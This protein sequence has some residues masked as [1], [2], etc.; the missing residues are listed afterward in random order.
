MRIERV[1]Q[2]RVIQLFVEQL[3]YS[4]AGNLEDQLN[5]NIREEDLKAWLTAQNKYSESSISRALFDF[6][7]STNISPNDDLYPINKDVYSKLRYG[8]KVK[9]DATDLVQTVWLID[10][11]NPLNNNFTI[12]EEVTV[13]GAN[14]KRPDIVLYI[15]GI[16]LGVL[17]LK[18]AS[19]VVNEGIRQNLDN[20]QHRFIKPFFTTI[21]LVLAG[22]DSQGLYYGTTKTSEKYFLKWKE[23]N[24]NYDPNKNILDQH[25]LQFC[26]KTRLLE[27]IHDFVVF[28]A[29]LKKLCRPNQFFGVKKAQ[30]FVSR[31][32]GG[33]IWHTQGSGKSLTMVWLAK[34]IREHQTDARL[35]IVTDRTELDEQIEKVFKGVDEPIYKTKSGRDLLDKLNDTTPWL[36]CSLIHKFGG[37]DENDIDEFIT[38]LKKPA[39]FKPKGNLYVFIDECHRTNSGNLHKAMKELLP[40]ALFIGF[41]GT[42]LLKADKKKSIEIFGKYIHT[43]KFDEAVQDGVV[44]DLLYEARDVDQKVT[45]QKGID[46][47]FE[48][49]TVGMNDL[50]KAELKQ[51]WGTIQ[52]ILST[53]DRLQKIAFDIIKDFK[54]KPRLKDGKGNAILVSGSIYEACRYYEIFQ[55]FGFKKCA[56]ITS[57]EPN[58]ASI[59]GETTGDGETEKIEQ[60]DIYQKMLNGKDRETFE[61]ETKKQFIDE[62]ANMQ[63]LIVVDKLLTGFDAPA[64]T[65]LYI[66]KQMQDHGLFQAICRVNRTEKEDKEFGYIVDYKN[67]FN[68]L[69]QSIADYTSDAFDNFEEDDVRGLLVDRLV[70]TRECMDDALE[71]I[72]QLCIGVEP[73]RQIEQFIKFFCGNTEDKD[74]LKE[75]EEKRLTFYK[76]VVALIRAY[77]NVAAEMKEA[78]YT[79]A[80]AEKIKATVDSYT[81]HRNS[82]KAASGDYIDL[83]K[84]E[85][86]M[87][88]LLDMYLSADPSRTI[89][90]FGDATLLQIIVEQGI[91]E[92]TGK[93]PNA[94][95]NSKEAMAETLEANMRKVITQEMPI[96]PVYYEKM[97]VLLLELIKQR[98]NGAIKYAE[99]LK[100]VEE[101]TKNIQP[102]ARKSEYPNNIN[103]P[104]KQALYDNL[105]QDED[106]AIVMDSEIQYVKK[107]N[108][109]GN[110]IK[111]REVR[112]AIAKHIDD[113]AKVDEIFEIIKNQKEYR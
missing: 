110:T 100:K 18:R 85:P 99:F 53:K 11:Q 24:Y 43:Y 86:E 6:K 97:S 55:N 105:E 60:Y 106:L 65:Y 101:L 16:A 8:V 111:E 26:D 21:Q 46:D 9:D 93:L 64:C 56:I 7:K 35:L 20:Q 63:L 3:G 27:L 67:L 12:A 113:S 66:D 91:E 92:A 104:A 33:I 57:Y 41:T 34:W 98:K 107:D 72:H 59:K 73:P 50:P 13:V 23:D 10:W 74:A 38:L 78:G 29:G 81:E 84:Y 14:T 17:E 25:L 69:N 28:D 89:S 19:V 61:K 48:V 77:N 95:R 90:N 108:W 45:D 103:T 75:T 79:Q 2:N 47:W 70:K 76:A 94:I 32:E 88:Q 40:D 5:S 44:L 96:N 39:D 112:I 83:K 1:T 68:S 15:N 49:V 51:K 87:R 37:N 102:N 62:P 82:I 71:A 22:N 30:K 36:M 109:I 52:K 54:V 31:K 42:P 4:Y 80:E 58:T